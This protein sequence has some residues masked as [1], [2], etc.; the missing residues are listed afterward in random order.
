MNG[1][2]AQS[3]LELAGAGVTPNL[4]G[5]GKHSLQGRRVQPSPSLTSVNFDSYTQRQGMQ[6]SPSMKIE[7]KC[8]PPEPLAMYTSKNAVVFKYKTSIRNRRSFLCITSDFK[9]QGAEGQQHMDDSKKN[10]L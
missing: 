10:N 3:H 1:G 8:D 6:V 9:I 4:Y 7:N 5:N 2:W